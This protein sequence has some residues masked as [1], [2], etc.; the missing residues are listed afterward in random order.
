LLAVLTG[1]GCVARSLGTAEPTL[2][3]KLAGAD[4]LLACAL[5]S[6]QAVFCW[7]ALSDNESLATGCDIDDADPVVADEFGFDMPE[8]AAA[9]TPAR[10]AMAATARRLTFFMEILQCKPPLRKTFAAR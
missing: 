4:S 3:V 9:E 7:L 5:M 8:A 1:T 2:A 10:S 6:F